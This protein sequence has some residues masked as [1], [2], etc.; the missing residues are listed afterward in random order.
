MA[1][2]ISYKILSVLLLFVLLLSHSLAAKDLDKNSDENDFAEFET[3]DDD[4]SDDAYEDEIETKPAERN[5]A[6]GTGVGDDNSDD[7]VDVE[8]DDGGESD[9]SDEAEEDLTVET[10]DDYDHFADEEEFE[11]YSRDKS[12]SKG[13]QSEP[14]LKIAKVPLHLR[15]NWEGFYLEI[16]MIAG[17]AAYALNF[18][19]GRS[20]NSKLATA[21]M[22]YNR[23]IM[24]DNFSIVG[25]DGSGDEPQQ[26]ILVKESESHYSL[27]CSGRVNCEGLLVE[28]KLLKRHDLVHVLTYMFKPTSDKMVATV[29]MSDEDMD[30]FV[31]AIYP[32]RTAG[33]MQKELQD[34]NF[35]CP[36]RRPAEKV[37]LPSTYSILSESA[38]MLSLLSVTVTK[39]I[40]DKSDLF[41]SL[42]F[43]DQ[44]VGYKKNPDE[45]E[46]PEEMKPQK[47]RKVLI[48]T[49]N[50]P[51][52]GKTKY[53]YMEM[54][55][56][57]INL[58]FHFMDKVKKFKLSKDA[59]TKSDKK[60]REMEESFWKQAHASRQ[61]AAQLRR[62]EK[63]RAE[64]ERIMNEDDTEKQRRWEE[65]A[66]KKEMKKRNPAFKMKQLKA[67][68]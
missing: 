39:L 63:Q 2:N 68:A 41:E 3:E 53:T 67:R 43:S 59:K 15:A 20:K 57:L 18:F 36:E 16:L 34:L 42:H 52:K 35:F 6:K 62:E 65:K 30:N 12:G 31:F 47:A 7:D 66:H 8:T 38:E 58:I 21:W 50:L 54:C 55:K 22:K 37:G 5:R 40:T 11:G 14:D 45:A 32:K 44:Y 60:R 49:F 4:E 29:Y 64:K 56:P 28:L 26:G 13:K 33:R 61:E 9:E 51:G 48:F 19:A 46:N 23:S 10:E 1:S 24:Q 27:W 25:D 17:L